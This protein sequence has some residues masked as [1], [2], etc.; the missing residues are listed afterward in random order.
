[1]NDLNRELFLALN[2]S[3][4]S[5]RI[6]IAFAI[7]A[8][9]YLIVLVPLHL[10]L[11]WIGGDRR[12]R[13]VA[14]TSL[15]ALVIAIAINQAVGLVAFTPRPFI[16]GLGTQLIE[17]RNSSSLPSNHGTIFFTY[18]AVL[19]L[20]GKRVLGLTTA[21]LGLLVAWA[22]IY[23]GIHYPI[24]M[25]AALVTSLVAAFAATWLMARF[26]TPLLAMLEGVYRRLFGLF[27]R[28]RAQF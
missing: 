3:P 11:V 21:A 23:L 22:R 25:A 14:L 4:A 2:G 6:A 12:M 9:K 27:I 13:F 7:F 19:M 10:V 5:P 8:A 18:A 1:M 26:G 15:M 28:R 16:V 24:D 17:H 20:F